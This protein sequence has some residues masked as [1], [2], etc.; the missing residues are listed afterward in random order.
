MP[1]VVALIGIFGTIEVSNNQINNSKEAANASITS[2]EKLAQA[3]LENERRRS[4]TEQ[5]LKILEIFNKQISS[6][7][8]HQRMLAVELLKGLSEDADLAQI[9][10]QAAIKDPSKQVQ[11]AATL[12]TDQSH[13][14][15]V[16]LASVRNLEDAKKRAADAQLPFPSEVYRAINGYF[17][18]TAGGYLSFAEAVRR[19]EVAKQKG[20]S[21]A[22]VYNTQQWGD[23]L[24]K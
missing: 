16:V 19:I 9:L 20:F 11:A 14:N 10:A 7:D 6:S 17:A 22:Y 3:N 15:F 8:P 18:V 12:I 21:D 24:L 2:A 4:K 13:N 23:N 1:L 5:E